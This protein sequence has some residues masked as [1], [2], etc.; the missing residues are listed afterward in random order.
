MS[1]YYRY[2]LFPGVSVYASLKIVIYRYSD[3]FADAAK[4]CNAIQACEASNFREG[5]A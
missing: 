5:D 1:R 3:T 2:Q 4:L